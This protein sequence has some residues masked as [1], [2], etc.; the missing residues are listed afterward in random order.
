VS[1]NSHKKSFQILDLIEKR[2]DLSAFKIQGIDVWPYIRVRF[3]IMY[4][5]QIEGKLKDESY[6]NRLFTKFK[7]FTLN[8]NLLFS[9]LKSIFTK[10]NF[11]KLNKKKH[12]I[13]TDVSSKR[14]LFNDSWYD[15]YTDPLLDDLLENSDD[16]CILETDNRFIGS[17]INFRPSIYIQ[18]Y[19]I[20][21]F[22]ISFFKKKPKIS[23]DFLKNYNIYSELLRDF[24]LDKFKLSLNELRKE[25][26][27]I[28]NLSLFYSKIINKVKPDLISMIQYSGYHGSA[29]CYSAN[30]LNISSLDIQ[31]GVQGDLH[32]T[33][34]FTNFPKSGY[35]VFPRK[36]L[37]WSNHEKDILDKSFD[38]SNSAIISGNLLLNKF[39]SQT[40]L[41]KSFDKIFKNKFESFLSKK[42]ILISL[43]WG[44]GFPYLIKDLI[45]KSSSDYFFLVRIHPSTNKMEYKKLLREFSQINKL[46]FEYIYSTK[47]PLHT[48]L[49]NVSFHVTSVSSVVIEA[50]EFNVKSIV[51]SIRGKNYYQYLIDNNK[52]F[53]LNNT[54]SII[55]FFKNNNSNKIALLKSLKNKKINYI[56]KL[57]LNK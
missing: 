37:V 41:S 21:I 35:N 32:P 26:A 3:L 33:Y 56:D 8:K 7:L 47:L 12:L 15:I 31:H 19:I 36:F 46:K 9:F 49:R 28:K 11:N 42:F 38:N 55:N 16:F 13:L 39:K 51:F 27:F 29:L 18:P 53:F 5:A 14:F 25:F 1:E 40:N 45:T 48:I 2:L 52:V 10:F 34:H 20:K 57:S 24:K 30:K 6:F 44:E 43:V 23:Q 17:K 22:L 4:F 54:K 50:L